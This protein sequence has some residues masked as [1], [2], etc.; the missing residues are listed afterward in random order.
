MFLH[1]KNF[2]V[3]AH[4]FFDYV[5]FNAEHFFPVHMFSKYNFVRLLVQEKYKK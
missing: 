4:K 2:L 5:L 3:L 1:V